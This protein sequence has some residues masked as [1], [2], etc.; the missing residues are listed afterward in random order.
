M[1]ECERI[2]EQGFLPQS[3]FEEE[4]RCGYTISTDKKKLWAVLLDLVREFDRVCKKHDLTYFICDGTLLGAVRHKGF[5]PWDDDLDVAMPREDYQKLLSLKEEF[6]DPYK[7]QTPYNEKGYYR[8]FYRICNVNTTFATEVFI[9]NEFDQGC[10]I[11]IFPYDRF[12][13]NNCDTLYDRVKLLARSLGVIMKMADPKYVNNEQAIEGVLKNYTPIEIY[14]EIEQLAIHA[15]N[16]NCQYE[17]SLVSSI[18]PYKK[19]AIPIECRRNII[20]IDFEGLKLPA[21]I[22]YD[23]FLTQMYGDYM[24]F[25]PI[26]KRVDWHT[27]HILKPDIPYKQFKQNYLNK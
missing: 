12:D 18:T 15:G 24:Q 1:T 14:E 17:T 11:D 20:N 3:F 6:K 10:F 26:E 16:S 27:G 5:I 25:P 21:P 2:I 7:L 23:T 22:G 13:I 9:N 19:K 4:V 8:T